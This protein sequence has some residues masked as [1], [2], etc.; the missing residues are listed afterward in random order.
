MEKLNG[1]H[2]SFAIFYYSEIFLIAQQTNINFFLGG[3]GVC[4]N[5]PDCLPMFL[6]SATLCKQILIKLNKVAVYK[7]VVYRMCIHKIIYELRHI[8][9]LCILFTISFGVYYDNLCRSVSQSDY[10]SY[11]T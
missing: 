5:Y 7:Y 4:R 3:G 6:L 10:R 2:E 1:L 8:S 9:S 11:T